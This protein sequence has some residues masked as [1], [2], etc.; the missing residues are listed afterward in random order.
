MRSPVWVIRLKAKAATEGAFSK[1][2][3]PDLAEGLLRQCGVSHN[4]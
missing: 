2:Q 4:A 1:T 3:L